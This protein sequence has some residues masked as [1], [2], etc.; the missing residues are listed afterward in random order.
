MNNNNKIRIP[1]LRGKIGDWFYY[2]GVMTFNDLA[3]R[4]NLPS[5]INKKYK[6]EELKLGDWI[7][8]DVDIK[9]IS[10]ISKY[11]IDNDQRFLNSL[12]LGIYDGEPTWQELDIYID[13]DDVQVFKEDEID[14]FKRT[15]GVLTLKGDESIFAID[16]QHRLLGI[17]NALK[18]NKKIFFEDEVSVIIVAHKTTKEGL[19]RTRRL[20]STLNRYAKPVNKSE[21]IA[22]SE[23][24]NCAILTRRLVENFNLFENKIIVNKNRSIS[25]KDTSS[26][27][28]IIMLYDILVTLITNSNIVG[29]P[30]IIIG[31]DKYLFT[32]NRASDKKLTQYEQEVKSLFTEIV[33]TIPTFKV[34][35]I[36]GKSINRSSKSSS[37]L[38]KVIGQ[39]IFFDILKVA[40]Q[41]NK[42]TE[43]INFFVNN[44]FSLTNKHFKKIFWDSETKTLIKDKS[45][46]KFCK[47][48]ILESMG[49]EVKRTKKDIELLETFKLTADQFS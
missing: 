39:N 41:E 18:I 19:E 11:L 44:E 28:S 14:Y 16:G 29:Y 34:F 31:E 45:R 20:F 27:T 2:S 25:Q 8:R 35:F 1:C 12:I 36:E 33:K 7:Q 42:L 48:L 49:I 13:K 43:A 15:F 37:L 30:G 22:L 4:V 47:L 24:D 9:R 46:Q 3:Q 23:D 32:N 21:I 5:E 38:F 26:F 17:R 40:K 10:P 6:L